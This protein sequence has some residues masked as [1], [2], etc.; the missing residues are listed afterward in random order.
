MQF[1]VEK[2][3]PKSI[4]ICIDQDRP[5]QAPREELR[6]VGTTLIAIARK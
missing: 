5:K 4:G 3:D 1:V 2:R 6:Y